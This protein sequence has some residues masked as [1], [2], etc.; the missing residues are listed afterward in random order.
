[1]IRGDKRLLSVGPLSKI[2]D[3]QGKRLADRA[4]QIDLPC[5]LIESGSTALVEAI[6]IETTSQG[7]VEDLEVNDYKLEEVMV[8]MR[9]QLPDDH[10]LLIS[11]GYRWPLTII[12]SWPM[13]MQLKESQNKFA[14]AVCETLTTATDPSF[15]SKSNR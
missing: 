7:F 13:L 3:R 2:S 5:V 8:E 9:S 10:Y 4:S 14:R 1:M 12:A 6:F 11:Y 15:G